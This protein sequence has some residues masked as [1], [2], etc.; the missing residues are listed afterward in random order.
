MKLVSLKPLAALA[1]GAILATSAFAS[2]ANSEFYPVLQC[3]GHSQPTVI[4]VRK[5][6]VTV[7]VFAH[8][9]TLKTGRPTATQSKI[10]RQS[11]PHGGLRVLYVGAANAQ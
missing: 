4:L 5:P 10:Q 6:A 3:F 2:D 1:T 7:G 9:A 11:D 8:G